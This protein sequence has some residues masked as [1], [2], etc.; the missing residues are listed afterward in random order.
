MDEDLK[1][2]PDYKEGFN[3]GYWLDHTNEQFSELFL[4]QY[5]EKLHMSNSPKNQGMADGIRQARQ[6]REQQKSQADSF[7]EKIKEMRDRQRNRGR[8]H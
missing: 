5:K 1:V 2:D 7:E 6:E 8:Q 3:S 4:K